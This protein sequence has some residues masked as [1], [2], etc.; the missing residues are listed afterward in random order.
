MSMLSFGV[1]SVFFVFSTV[2]SYISALIGFT[3]H[4]L[5]IYK[6][7]GVFKGFFQSFIVL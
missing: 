3:K 5:S 6:D 4:S 1:S 2:L 7:N